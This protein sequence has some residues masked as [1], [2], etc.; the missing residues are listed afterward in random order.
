MNTHHQF[1]LSVLALALCA[2]YSGAQAEE[3][4]EVKQLTTPESTISTGAGYWSSN[5]PQR[6]VYDAMR[7]SGGYLLLDADIVKRDDETGTWLKLKAN[8]LGL[9]NRELSAEYLRQG[10][11]GI[12]VDYDRITREGPQTFWTTLQ[13][14]GTANQKVVNTN[15]ASAPRQNL[16]LGTVRE[17]A[18]LSIYKNL[19]KGL[20]FNVSFKNEDK[21]GMRPWS[22][23][24]S[25]HFATEPVD[26]TTRQLEA[27][28]SYA[29]KTWQLRGGYN[30]SW[31]QN[32]N[33]LVRVSYTG[34]ASINNPTYLSFPGDN[35]AHQL[36]LN[37]GYNIT[38]TTR[39]T[40]KLEYQRAL[41]NDYLPTSGVTDW[42]APTQVSVGP[43]KLDGR[44]DTRLVHLGLTSR[45]F[46]NLSVNASV[47]YH[48]VDDKTP[49]RTFSTAGHEYNA[50][51]PDYVRN[52]YKTLTSKLEGTYRFAGGYNVTAG[53]EDKRRERPEPL[54][55]DGAEKETVV[56][57]RTKV[58][59][60]TG[61]LELRRALSDTL[62]GGV[63]Y[64]HS[65]RDGSEYQRAFRDQDHS[66]DIGKGGLTD[67]RN[68]T[69]PMHMADRDRDRLRVSM[70]WAP[71]DALALQ[72]VAEEGRDRYHSQDT[73]IFGLDKGTNRLYSIDAA[74]TV[75]EKLKLTAWY[76]Y[77]YSK[78]KQS[79][80]R[81]DTTCPTCAGGG[82]GDPAIKYSDLQET[83][84]SLGLGL[85]WEA[86]HSLDVGVNLEVFRS[87][88]KYGQRVDLLAPGGSVV[89]DN[90]ASNFQLGVPNIENRSLRLGLFSV[91][92]FDKASSV[93]IDFIHERWRTND[94]TWQFADGSPFVYGGDANVDGTTVV[95][96]PKQ[97][98][99]FIGVRYIYK[100]Q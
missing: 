86:T 91:Y 77:D 81:T 35:E 32:N 97:V 36:F 69:N 14:A 1:H 11:V 96:K 57:L 83:G 29:T 49:I 7:D 56:P 42:Y 82:M 5:R 84:N 78:A 74:Y 68:L 58:N 8:D 40:L 44:V 22:V 76:S 89:R 48:D 95:T 12:K 100:F 60:K 90:I 93:R 18:G 63:S 33:P 87:V 34:A 30:G 31:Y 59:E 15:L 92:R 13:G 72:F 19:G 70:D 47:R 2:A 38:Q 26:S 62:N 39:V 28:L 9:D 80:Y 52:S 53:Y 99:N 25:V 98:S 51:A 16:V 85:R 61:R 67:I 54:L 75:N 71:T 23:G 24:H 27:A 37:G 45:P 79:H 20:D 6:G 55:A 66:N 65:S 94:W 21:T 73:M 88:N 50:T 64:L 3:L 17:Q 41:Q 43:S 46:K 10:N 4:D